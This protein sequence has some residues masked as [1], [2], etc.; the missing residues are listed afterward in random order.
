MGEM[1]EKELECPG[2]GHKAV[3]RYIEGID[4]TCQGCGAEI[5]LTP[6]VQAHS[7]QGRVARGKFDPKLQKFLKTKVSDIDDDPTDNHF[8]TP[9]V[10]V[11]P[12]KKPPE[13]SA[14]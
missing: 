7:S 9:D 6:G 10:K 4:P 14:H 5:D 1:V 11:I 13:G 3:Y 12:K 8:L 2:C